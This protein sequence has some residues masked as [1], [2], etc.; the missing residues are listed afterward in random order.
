MAQLPQFFHIGTQ[1]A[2]STFFYNLIKQHPQIGVSPAQ[3]VQ[4][5]NNKDKFNQGV[6]WYKD[7]FEPNEYL[8]DTTPKYFM[9]GD[10]VAKRIDEVYDTTD[11]LK[12]LLI[13]R[14]PIYY[15]NSHFQMQKTKGKIGNW[16][17]YREGDTIVDFLERNPHY[18]QRAYYYQILN[19]HWFE[20]FDRNQFKIIIFERF[21][22]EPKVVMDEVVDFLGLPKFEFKLPDTEKNSKLRGKWLYELR[23]KLVQW[24]GLKNTLKESKLFKFF[25]NN[26]LTESSS[27]YLDEQAVEYLT[28]AY[29]SEVSKLK[30]LL[31]REIPQWEEF[32]NKNS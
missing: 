23:N 19:D 11:D 24:K 22:S 3:E 21:T 5:F 1:R 28:E 12:F 14:N 16:H 13:L 20:Y 17:D 6:Q 7:K 8:I 25:Y 27:K 4:F 26:L 29:R 18:L 30:E 2:G 32:N 15:V 9:A 31:E 10:K